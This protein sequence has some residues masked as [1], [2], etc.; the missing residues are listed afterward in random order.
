M[1]HQLKA[2]KEEKLT[3][4]PKNSE[5]VIWYLNT[6]LVASLYPAKSEEADHG[7]RYLLNP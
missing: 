7:F 2:R 1:Q 3:T 6:N 4:K 5:H